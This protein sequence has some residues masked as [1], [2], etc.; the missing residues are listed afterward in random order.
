MQ[1]VN[2]VAAEAPL[3]WPSRNALPEMLLSCP[4]SSSWAGVSRAQPTP[5]ASLRTPCPAGGSKAS[6]RGP[7]LLRAARERAPFPRRWT[8]PIQRGGGAPLS[9]GEGPPL[10]AQG[11]RRAVQRRE[12]S[13][14]G[15]WIKQRMDCSLSTCVKYHHLV[16]RKKKHL[17]Q[18]YLCTKLKVKN[19]DYL[20]VVVSSGLSL[21]LFCSMRR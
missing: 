2:L 9:A 10:G 3:P 4:P 1:S 5:A 21:S 17:R 13:L 8:R 19:T 18:R 6:R 14:G 16:W 7:S 11:G 12:K 20:I 15:S